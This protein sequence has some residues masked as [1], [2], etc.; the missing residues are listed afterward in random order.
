MA[1][2][3]PSLL[4][5]WKKGQFLPSRIRIQLTKINANLCG[6]GSATLGS[7]DCQVA[8]IVACGCV[9]HGTYAFHLPCIFLFYVGSWREIIKLYCVGGA[10]Q[11]QYSFIIFILKKKNFGAHPIF[12]LLHGPVLYLHVSV[13]PSFPSS[14]EYAHSL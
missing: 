11:F 4:V 5:I 1:Y 7:S 3:L 8:S 10:Q 14:A 12:N 9:G 2:R 13:A 6:F